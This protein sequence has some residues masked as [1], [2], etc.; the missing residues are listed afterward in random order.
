MAEAAIGMLCGPYATLDDLPEGCP[1]REV[2]SGGEDPSD[3]VLE[4]LLQQASEVIFALLAYP[5]FG[6]CERTIHPCRVNG[7]F[8]PSAQARVATL[9]WGACSCCGCDAVWLPGP[10]N[11]ITEVLVDGAAL[12]PSEYELHDGFAL[13]RVA[14]SWPSGGG[15]AAEERF[16]VTYEMGL[17][18]PTL[19]RDATVEL[20]NQMWLASCGERS[21][22]LTSKVTSVSTQGVSM[23]F[24]R[25]RLT[26]ESRS[27]ARDE[28][29]GLPTVG[30]ALAAYNP[31]GELLRTVAWSPDMPYRNRVIR[32]FS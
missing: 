8:S 19:V 26:A 22:K 6:P 5:T 23:G 16:V 20:A 28:V 2:S 1:C 27:L 29:D 7:G 3:D 25:G 10:V 32:T 17:P 4:D 30:K 15:A 21:A 9:R 18:V 24:D 12:D 13:V 14:G 11:D 31:T